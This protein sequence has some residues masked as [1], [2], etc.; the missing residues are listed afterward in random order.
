MTLKIYNQI[1]SAT[2]WSSMAELASKLIMPISTIILARLLTPEDFGILVT[3]TMVISFAELFTDAG[4]HKYLIQHHFLSDDEKYKSTTVAFWTNLSISVLAWILIIFF[5]KEIAFLVGCPG[6]EFIIIISCVC[7]PIVSFSSIY[8]ALLKKELNFKTLFFVRIISTL[9]P[10]FITV[11]LAFITRSYWAL[12]IG[13]IALNLATAIILALKSSWKPYL[14]FDIIYLK[15]MLSFSIWSMFES[16]SI[17]LT[18]YIDIFIV[19]SVLNQHYLGIYRTSMTTVS[20]I[21]A[22]IISA[23]TPVLYSSLSQL[24]N[25]RDEF[26]KLFFRFQKMVGM[27]VIPLGFGIYI[28]RSLI[29]ELLLGKQWHEAVHFVGLWGLTS[30]ITIVLAHYSSE[31]YRSMGKPKISVIVQFLHIAALLPVVLYFVNEKF[32][33]L[34]LARSLV[35]L[36]LVLINL[37]F[38]HFLVKISPYMMLKNILPAFFCSV[39]MFFSVFILPETTEMI[40][41][42]LYVAWAIA[43]YFVAISCFPTERYMMK[44]II[45]LCFHKRRL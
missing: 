33:T 36:Q 38:M 30:S 21:T 17:W 14:F 2:K 39:L 44:K 37:F 29:V 6:K 43:V 9:V 27:L 18:G 28:F 26:K 16:V 40:K 31:V 22:L 1:I 32:E 13:M 3:A 24:Q 12:I 34:C 23:T 25:N 11:P 20:Q 35:R 19:G 4:F 10:L 41:S 5:S 7:I 8:S 45:E 42:F 15:Q